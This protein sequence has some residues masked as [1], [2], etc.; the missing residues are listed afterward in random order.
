MSG[1]VLLFRPWRARLRTFSERALAPHEIAGFS[2]VPPAVNRTVARILP[3]LLLIALAYLLGRWQGMR[4]G[5]TV[6]TADSAGRSTAATADIDE[7]GSAQG[8]LAPIAPVVS[9]REL[10]AR[11]LADLHAAARTMPTPDSRTFAFFEQL[12][13]E[14]L[15]AVSAQIRGMPAGN[16][17]DL[18][19]G[20]VIRRWAELDGPAALDEAALF[21]ALGTR[22]NAEIG[23]WEAWG[24]HDPRAAAA[25]ATLAGPGAV[26]DRAFAA[27]LGG[28]ATR[29]PR[30]ALEL[31]RNS[32]ADFRNAALGPGSLDQIVAAA[33]GTGQRETIR[34]MIAEQP[35]GET[36][37]RLAAALCAEWGGHYPDDALLWLKEALPEGEARN[38]AMARMFE[39]LVQKDPSL[40]AT[41]GAGFP[42]ARHRSGM[43]ASAVSSWAE[44]SPGEAEL[45]INEQSDSPEL[46]GATFA[47]AA[48]FIGAKDLPKAF[49]WIRRLRRDE[50]R[51]E[52]LGNL[53]RTW[54]REHPA[55]FRQFLDQTSL[56]RAE[57]DALL[58]KVDPKG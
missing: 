22:Q 3:W 37:D 6:P 20:M 24:S 7:Q 29:D 38:Q 54:S 56:N 34:A 57:L 58:S 2:D 55:E 40:A 51:S 11:D 44:I 19:F 17:Q 30:L 13:L 32:P 23:A 16:E 46:D 15:P 18:F 47:M 1:P 35:E 25:R 45:W 50:A 52:M 41:W 9:R 12:Q 31:W 4:T 8:A 53:G 36:R 42:D 48:H 10:L 49:S 26:R 43:I 39:S 28:A 5:G 27:L 21:P 14:D 33:C